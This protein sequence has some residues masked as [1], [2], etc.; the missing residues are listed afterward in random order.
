LA[1]GAGGCGVLLVNDANYA[2][3]AEGDPLHANAPRSPAFA[4]TIPPR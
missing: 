4:T 3:A 2:H 1:I